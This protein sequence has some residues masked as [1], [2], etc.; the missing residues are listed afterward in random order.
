MPDDSVQYQQCTGVCNRSSLC[1]SSSCVECHTLSACCTSWIIMNCQLGVTPIATWSLG[2]CSVQTSPI[3]SAGLFFHVTCLCYQAADHAGLYDGSQ[4]DR[5]NSNSKPSW[6]RLCL[7]RPAYALESM[8]VEGRLWIGLACRGF[9]TSHMSQL[10]SL[11]ASIVW[12]P[13][14]MIACMK[15]VSD[16]YQSVI[17]ADPSALPR[18]V[19]EYLLRSFWLLLATIAACAVPEHGGSFEG[20]CVG[21]YF[22]GSS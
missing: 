5:S 1:H 19:L 9:Q 4:I 12:L 6:H 13:C 3:M 14:S 15:L 11:L 21:C 22:P 7:D 10:L 17:L 2:V 20:P 8:I 16:L 18:E